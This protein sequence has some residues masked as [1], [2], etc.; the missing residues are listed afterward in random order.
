MGWQR[1]MKTVTQF[2][3]VAI[4][5]LL[6]KVSGAQSTLPDFTE[7]AERASAAVVSIEATRTASSQRAGADEA[8]DPQDMPEFFRRF[9]GQ[10]GMPP[11]EP[12]DQVSSGS[13]FL[14]SG[15]GEVLTNHHVID[16]ADEVVVRLPDRRE[17]EATVI[18][19]DAQADI[20]LLRIKAKGL[21][22]LKAGSSKN[23]RP[24]QWVFA[25]G[26]PFG[27]LD[28]TVTVGVVSGVGRR[29]MDA[30]QQYTPFIQ[31]DVAINRG[32]SGGP[33]L[34][35]DGEV[36]GINSQIFSNSGGYM[37]VS[38]AIPIEV[39]TNTAKQLRESGH[40][41]RGQLGV[42]I[43]NVDRKFAKTLGL[44]RSVGALVSS[45]TPGSAAEKAGVKVGDVI[46]SFNGI[47][48]LQSSDLPPMVGN[49]APASKV[50]LRVLRD[51]KER[52]L[53][54]VL[55]E[56]PSDQS[57]ASTG[58]GGG[59]K[60]SAGV[61]GLVV[62]TPSAE[63]RE[64]LGLAANEGVL[65]ARVVGDAARRAGLREGDVI[66]RVGRTAVASAKAFSDAIAEAGDSEAVMLLVRRGEQTQF[67]A[68]APRKAE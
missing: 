45:V 26:S 44:D 16:G 41:R 14:I 53:N 35:T 33:L 42:A 40:V 59:D 38:F 52:E 64:Q 1:T 7:L 31:T 47:E 37:G 15:D 22:Y 20:A 21:P 34:N 51:G 24:G 63:E 36:V 32:N 28:N 10:P 50:K 49:T 58:A 62:Q 67:V 65:I 19:S 9:F 11:M 46:L 48:I 25:I 68:I 57:S 54:A 66:L 5:V 60:A 27:F 39:A 3:F 17:F 55:G 61:L 43:Q 56:V 12:R 8:V 29:S 6:S 13:G 4:F 30:S 2:A 18:G 23:L